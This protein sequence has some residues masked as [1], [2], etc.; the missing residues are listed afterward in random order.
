MFTWIDIAIAV[1]ITSVLVGF[2]CIFMLGVSI[3]NREGEAYQEG[4]YKGYEDGKKV[5]G[6]NDV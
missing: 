3:N 2:V 1:L 5:G 4:Y 6:A